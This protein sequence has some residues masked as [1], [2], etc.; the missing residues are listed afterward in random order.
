MHAWILPHL[1]TH[2][3]PRPAECV[4][5]IFVSLTPQRPIHPKDMGTKWLVFYYAGE[6][7]PKQGS[8]QAYF[9]HTYLTL[10]P[11]SLS[12]QKA[13]LSIF[14]NQEKQCSLTIPKQG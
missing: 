9:S 6:T 7:G 13:F 11:T 5:A 4:S 3:L 14:Y 2:S 1:F 8:K 10:H 12:I